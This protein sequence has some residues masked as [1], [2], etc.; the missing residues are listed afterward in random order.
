[1]PQSSG[2]SCHRAR[3]GGDSAGARAQAE[4]AGG[5]AAG[6]GCERNAPPS[7]SAPEGKLTS[8]CGLLG[9][10]AEQ[11]APPCPRN[12][13]KTGCLRRDA[14][15]FR[16]VGGGLVKTY[17]LTNYGYSKCLLKQ[18]ISRLWAS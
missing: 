10:G 11:D 7:G 4:A 3:A 12:R 17:P 1:M 15:Y 13:R 14:F 6:S 9:V 16:Q 8:Q 18:I 2:R 5:E